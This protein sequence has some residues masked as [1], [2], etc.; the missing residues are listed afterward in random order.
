MPLESQNALSAPVTLFTQDL[1]GPIGV[2]TRSGRPPK[3]RREHLLGKSHLAL[4]R[5]V[6]LVGGALHPW[7]RNDLGYW[8]E[9]IANHDFLPATNTRKVRAQMGP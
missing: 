3:R 7:E 9:L 2:D 8:R 6:D 5:E 4:G 1:Q